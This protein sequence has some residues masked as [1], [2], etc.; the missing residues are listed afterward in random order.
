M[1]AR[2]GETA[3]GL[4]GIVD[5]PLQTRQR[6]DHED[7]SAKTVPAAL[8]AENLHGLE[9]V[10]LLSRVIH[11]GHAR[12]EGV[13]D[14]STED[15]GDITRSEGD[16]ELRGLGVGVTRLGE[17]VL[18]EE[19]HDVLEGGELHHGVGDLAAPQRND[20]LPQS[21][22]ALSSGDLL[23]GGTQLGG[24]VGLHRRRLDAHLGGLHG[25]Q[26]DIGEELSRGG[27]SQVDGVLPVLGGLLAHQV[28]VQILEHLVATELEQTLHGITEEG[29]LP[30][31][32]DTVA[33]PSLL[34]SLLQTVPQR[35]VH[36]RVRLTTAL[37][38]IE[39]ADGGVG[40]TAREN[41]SDHAQRIELGVVLGGISGLDSVERASAKHLK[42]LRK[43]FMAKTNR[44]SRPFRGWENNH[45][46]G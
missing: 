1:T 3:E 41:T 36:A 20:A 16:G 27:S 33:V 43:G 45:K 44:G 32:V 10:D 34:G 37:H 17:Q 14:Q 13:R 23:H 15:T 24:E 31:S 19:G 35:L 12:V 18:V 39:R 28:D 11:L 6:T 21:L 25:A 22:G 40:G 30:A 42:Q 46:L 38:Q 5:P 9:H 7:T 26:E 29:G 2:R 8:P 4:P